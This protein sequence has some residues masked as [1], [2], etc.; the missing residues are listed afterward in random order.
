MKLGISMNF[1][2]SN[3]EEWAKKYREAGLSSVVFPCNYTAEITKVDAYVEAC[4]AYELTIAEV[5][6][7]SNPLSL[8][9]VEKK[10]NFEYC[11][12]QLE[13]A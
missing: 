5:G 13:L 11:Q 12:H 1:S 8:D 7:W 10:K 3:P 4:K 9:P 6:A 2:H